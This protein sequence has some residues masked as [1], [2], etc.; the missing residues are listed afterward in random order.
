MWASLVISSHNEGG[1][2]WRTVRSCIE[3]TSDL[4]CEIIIADDASTDGSVEE[5][6]HRFPGIR[7]VS[8]RTRRGVSPTKDM[9]A[10]KARGEILIF[11]DGHT[12]PEPRALERLLAGVEEAGREAIVTP[13]VPELD[14]ESWKNSSTNVGYGYFVKLERLECGWL[15][16]AKLRRSGPFYEN[17]ALIGCCVA[18]SRKLYFRLRGFD[19]HM[20]EWG[21]ED[22]DFGL[23]AWLMGHP[24]LLHPRAT[25]GHRFRAG[26]ENF[27]VTDEAVLANQLRMARKNL[28]DGVWSDWLRSARLRKPEDVWAGAWNRF[29]K[30]RSSVEKERQYL[31]AHRKRDEFWYAER[32]GLDWPA[33][34]GG[35]TPGA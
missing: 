7:V 27:S 21:V 13:R 8:H 4:G 16:L 10:R 9:G 6:R 30:G 35:F 1:R 24:I 28:T 23:K 26:F 29:L 22:L 2:L 3:T 15:D 19:Q 34:T 12:K 32:F 20:L 18:I 33:R 17:P 25:V 14:D 31:L 11:L 5:T